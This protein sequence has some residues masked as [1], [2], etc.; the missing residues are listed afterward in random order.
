[1][2]LVLATDEQK[3]QRD[4]LM[5]TTWGDPL[6]PEQWL[7]REERLRAQAW[8]KAGMQT[9]FLCAE[10]S[11]EILSSCETFRMTS[12]LR[13]APGSTYG[14]ASVFTEEKLRGRSFSGELLSR[15]LERL[16]AEDAGAQASI[17]FSEV[18]ARI[19][20]RLGYVARAEWDVDWLFPPLPGEPAGV[21]PPEA[22]AEGLA[23]VPRPADPFVVFPTAEQLGWHRERERL[24]SGYL[25]RQ[26]AMGCGARA[27]EST[28]LWVANLRYQEL[29]VLWIHA[30]N[31]GE[32]GALIESARRV[33]GAASLKGVRLWN[34][35]MP[36]GW[37]VEG[38]GGKAV[39]RPLSLAMIKP[40]CEGLHPDD[41]RS[42]QRAVW[43]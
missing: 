25:G 31:A 38:S 15:V 9:W 2:R 27:G 8:A 5:F 14:I 36:E 4:S 35:P 6:T 1:M 29:F 39:P 22:L 24:Y 12:A 19:Y 17:L 23:R 32:A 26:R 28:I 20:E 37:T 33:A 40:L 7:D 3:R 43:I 41:W 42:I 30:A 10:G 11:G 13:G 16:R 21:I 18:G 34:C